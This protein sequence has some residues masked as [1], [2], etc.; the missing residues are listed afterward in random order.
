M[1]HI[2]NMEPITPFKS[3][4]TPPAR[5]LFERLAKSSRPDLAEAA[6][7]ELLSR[8]SPDK[9]RPQDVR[10]IF[11][12]HHVSSGEI[13]AL[14]HRMWKSAFCVFAADSFIT[15]EEH[16]YLE[17]LRSLLNIGSD[18]AM[19]VE[20]EILLPKFKDAVKNALAD[21]HV[22]DAEKAE[23]SQLAAN[24]RLSPSRANDELRKASLAAINQLWD[25]ANADN[26]IDP[27]E[28]VKLRAASENLG[29]GFAD[30]AESR[31]KFAEMFHQIGIAPQLPTVAT[32][33]NL[34]SGEQVH[35]KCDA[36]W[37]E[38]RKERGYDVLKEIDRGVVHIT[39]R[40]VLFQGHGKTTSLEYSKII[41]IELFRDAVLLKK[42]SGR[43]PYLGIDP[44][45][46]V[47]VVYLLLRRLMA[48]DAWFGQLLPAEAPD[49]PPHEETPAPPKPITLEPKDPADKRLERLLSELD[50]MVGLEPVKKEIRTL[51]NLARVRKMR[52][53][54]GMRVPPA[55]YH[56]VF[57]GPPGT[58]KTTVGRLVG[59]ILN[60]IGILASGHQIE[61]DRAELV[62]GYV[63]QTAIKTD[64]AV[65]KALG[66]VLF[67]DEAYS[68]A[69][70][71][72]GEDFGR[73]AIETL[74]KLMEDNRDNLVVIA[75]GYR[76]R[77]EDF[78]AS[79]PGL[80][81]R[82]ARYIDFPDYSA[83]ELAQIFRHLCFDAHYELSEKADQAI[84]DLFLELYTRKGTNFG[85][86][87]LVRN[88]FEETIANQANRLAT[89]ESPSRKDL[90]SLESDDIPTASGTVK[91]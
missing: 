88:L 47:S 82:F 27:D 42:Q 5:T 54:E 84:D 74:L 62:A 13:N 72:S 23:L 71:Q 56:M 59:G 46:L 77:M 20:D 61:V 60:S 70:S 81:S 78:L 48:G 24:L 6:L 53:K 90:E 58:G 85:N 26:R 38:M 64:A 50:S 3:G 83:L 7:R 91:Y 65:K 87:R 63:G 21:R 8:T 12:E 19:Q 66:G 10:A 17:S 35:L 15:A 76:D 25:E 9:V 33:L 67:I 34:S 57:S 80:Q 39:S 52:E 55:S 44:V 51:V 86:A 11:E 37:L 29:I 45:E 16:G 36:Q 41:D 1:L 40:R 30:A 18:F 69:A 89:L 68:L 2:P 79:N 22:S 14:R 28:A 4:R 49:E 32:D 73:E 31:I 43:N 75:A